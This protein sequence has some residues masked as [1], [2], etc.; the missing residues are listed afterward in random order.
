M[1]TMKRLQVYKNSGWKYVF[2]Y[3]ELQGIITT[4]DKKKALKERD[5]VYFKNRFGNDQFRTIKD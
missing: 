2:C 3:N 1:I 4:K 5:L